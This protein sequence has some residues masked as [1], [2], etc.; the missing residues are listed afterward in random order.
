MKEFG[1][2][3]R[4]LKS[5]FNKDFLTKILDNL[6]STERYD[7]IKAIKKEALNHIVNISDNNKWLEMI[8]SDYCGVTHTSFIVFGFIEVATF[9][10]IYEKYGKHHS[11][12]ILIGEEESYEK[13]EQ[14]LIRKI[15]EELIT[16]NNF[17]ESKSKNYCVVI[18]MEYGDKYLLKKIYNDLF[19][20]LTF[21][22]NPQSYGLTSMD[23][24]RQV[25]KR[26]VYNNAGILIINGEVEKIDINSYVNISGINRVHFLQPV[27]VKKISKKV[28]NDDKGTHFDDYFDIDNLINKLSVDAEFHW[29]E[30]SPISRTLDSVLK[31]YFINDSKY[32]MFDYCFELEDGYT[33]NVKSLEYY[34]KRFCEEIDKASKNNSICNLIDY[35][36]LG[37]GYLLEVSNKVD[38]RFYSSA[39]NREIPICEDDSFLFYKNRI[40]WYNPSHNKYSHLFPH[41]GAD[42]LRV[43][44]EDDKDNYFPTLYSKYQILLLD[45]I[46]KAVLSEIDTLLVNEINRISTNTNKNS[47]ETGNILVTA[48]NQHL[49]IMMLS[50]QNNELNSLYPNAM[51]E[52]DKKMQIDKLESDYEKY[53]TALNTITDTNSKISDNK[54]ADML[55]TIQIASIV[56]TVLGWILVVFQGQ[57]YIAL[58]IVFSIVSVV[59]AIII[60]N[61]ISKK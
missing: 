3:F 16:N 60:K 4:S 41:C 58:I 17:D 9:N 22:I 35:E 52:I 54:L 27:S 40:I 15:E 50:N 5:I 8:L 36:V 2:H 39:T 7:R 1:G 21:N 29:Y 43:W 26:D 33:D 51:D 34:L 31:F 56:L 44:D 53:T 38:D 49:S 28:I 25:L 10:D 45:I 61:I 48:Y 13:Q 30:C 20:Y 6:P 24:L 42:T 14:E 46:K 12:E 32:G 18:L 47:Q 55:N 59:L 57:V 19:A 23:A 37:D 11:Q